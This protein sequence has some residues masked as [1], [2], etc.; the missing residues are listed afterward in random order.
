MLKFIKMR[1]LLAVFLLFFPLFYSQAQDSLLEQQARAYRDE[2]YRLQLRG[3]LNGA[4]SFYQKASQMDPNF[5]QAF[6]DA[7]VILESKGQ[8]ERAIQMYEKAIKVDPTCLAAYTNLA[9]LYEKRGDVAKATFY[10]KKRY[11]LGKKGDYWWLVSQQHLVSL[12]TYPEVKKDILEFEAS[13]LSREISYKREQEKLETIEEAKFHFEIGKKAFSEKDY[14]IAVKEF[15]TVLFLNP[16]DEKLK[17]KTRDYY[18]QAERFYLKNQAFSSTQRAL[19][20]IKSG[21]FASA[22]ERLR[23]AL[24]AVSGITQ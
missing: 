16:P 12:G 18:V 19:D 6:N 5:A 23:D 2:G 4:L 13:T 24:K 11:R 8:E 20:Y 21:D 22:G 1:F 10:W 7:G 3:D 15:R 9:F 17:S 14:E